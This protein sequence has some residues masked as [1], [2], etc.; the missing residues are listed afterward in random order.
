MVPGSILTPIPPELANDVVQFGRWCMTLADG[1][2]FTN[3]MH[4]YRSWLETI[5]EEAKRV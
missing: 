3:G 1:S 4:Q 5:V 2:Q